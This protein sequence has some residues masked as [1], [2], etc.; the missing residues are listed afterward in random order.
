MQGLITS[1]RAA[2]VYAF[3]ARAG[4]CPVEALAVMFGGEKKVQKAVRALTGAGYVRRVRVQGVEM[5]GL[6]GQD[7]ST[8]RIALGWF[9]V[10]LAE[11]GG[12]YDAETRKARFPSGHV[13]DVAVEERGKVVK[14]GKFRVRLEKLRENR[15]QEAIAS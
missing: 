4:A 1:E 10:R 11:T 6:P 8:E 13:L 5:A 12:I 3:L 7:F 15:L 14:V 2:K 9:A